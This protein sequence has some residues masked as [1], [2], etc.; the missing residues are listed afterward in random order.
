MTNTTTLVGVAMLGILCVGVRPAAAQA[1]IP[2]FNGDGFADLAVG[3]P[4]EDIGTTLNAGALGIVYGSAAALVPAGNQFL[5]QSAVGI[6]DFPETGDRFGGSR[7][8]GD[9]N[10]DG[11]TDLAVG[12]PGESLNGFSACGAVHVLYG[13]ASGITTAGTRLFHQDLP[14]IHEQ[15]EGYD[16]FGA[17]LAAGDFNGDGYL[18]LA[19]G[20]PGDRVKGQTG[21][22]AVHVL[23]G[24]AT[25]LTDNGSTLWTQYTT[26]IADDP[27]PGDAFGKALAAADF[28]GDGVD[29]LA[30]AAPLENVGTV[31]HAG[32]VHLI[33]GTPSGLSASGSQ[34]W[35]QDVTGVP[36]VAEEAD[37]FGW[38][39]AVGDFN[40]DFYDDLAV[41]VPGETTGSAGSAGAAHVFYGAPDGVTITGAQLWHQNSTGI[42][43]SCEV[44]D[45]FGSSLA[46]GDLDGDGF[47]DLAVGVPFE[48][49]GTA[50]EA[51]AVSV[52]F[53]S[54]TGVRSAGN[55]LLYQGQPSV[56]ET[57]ESH[58]NFGFSVSV[59][60]FDGNGQADLVVGVPFESLGAIDGAGALHVLYNWVS[61]LPGGSMVLTQDTP[62]IRDSAE[63]EDWLG[64]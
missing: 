22:G 18:D 37:G 45:Q 1:A 51:G 50:V 11:F 61:G 19:I 13:S 2:D 6:S 59:G 39:L 40:G 54:L 32:A 46:A 56:G 12:A 28:N 38:S 9:F 3:I 23:P 64:Y 25:G 24:S 7:A 49:V 27:E 29:D 5:F 30:V 31:F 16:D 63:R 15:C 47:A 17:A 60:D 14:R 48:S 44:G 42:L 36:D 52:L 8:W 62:G 33:F 43:D 41:G 58:D 35:H 10:G 53:G 21:A 55:Q 26:G 4:Y 34:L 57:L 20:V